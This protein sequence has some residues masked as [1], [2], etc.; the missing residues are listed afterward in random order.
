MIDIANKRESFLFA[1]LIVTISIVVGVSKFLQPVSSYWH[2]NSPVEEF[3]LTVVNF[4]LATL[5]GVQFN[6]LGVENFDISI[7]PPCHS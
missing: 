7:N 2:R 4:I 6:G 1:A 3:T 5:L